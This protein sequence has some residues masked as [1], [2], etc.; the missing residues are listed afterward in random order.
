[1]NPILCKSIPTA[2]VALKRTRANGPSSK[3]ESSATTPTARPRRSIIQR[4]LPLAILL[5]Q[6]SILQPTPPPSPERH[7]NP[8]QIHPESDPPTPSRRRHPHPPVPSADTPPNHSVPSIIHRNIRQQRDRRSS[9]RRTKRC[10]PPRVDAST[11]APGVPLLRSH[12]QKP[13]SAVPA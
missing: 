12:A 8:K 5:R 9:H 6:R 1:M 3:A 11:R 13:I 7:P 2:N 4:I 10:K